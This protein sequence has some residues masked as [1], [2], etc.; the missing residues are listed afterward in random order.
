MW[1]CST[2]Q[3]TGGNVGEQLGSKAKMKMVIPYR[4]GLVGL[5]NPWDAQGKGEGGGSGGGVKGAGGV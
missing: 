4:G 1:L 2:G 5:Q 3:V